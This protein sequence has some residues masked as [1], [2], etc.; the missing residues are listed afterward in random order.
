VADEVCPSSL[1]THHNSQTANFSLIN[2]SIM[3]LHIVSIL[4]ES[5]IN[6]IKEE[7]INI[8]IQLMTYYLPWYVEMYVLHF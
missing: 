8:V 2:N 3:V 1:I 4:T 7:N 6:Q 5:L